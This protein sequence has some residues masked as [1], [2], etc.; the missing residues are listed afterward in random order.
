MPESATSATV[1]YRIG[2]WE[3]RN[4]GKEGVREAGRERA[5]GG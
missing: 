4:T 1:E 2:G 3:P 5:E